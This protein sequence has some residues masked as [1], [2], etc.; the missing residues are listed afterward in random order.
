MSWL[1]ETISELHCCSR[2]CSLHVLL[3]EGELDLYFETAF[4]V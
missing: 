4:E 3:L 2:I 1:L